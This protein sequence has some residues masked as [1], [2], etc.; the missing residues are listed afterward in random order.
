MRYQQSHVVHGA[1]V[2]V[3]ETITNVSKTNG[4]SFSFADMTISTQSPPYK[5]DGEDILPPL[6][7]IRLQVGEKIASFWKGKE[8]SL[9]T[10]TFD[11]KGKQW[12]DKIIHTFNAY[13]VESQES[14]TGAENI[15]TQHTQQDMV[16]ITLEQMKA[17]FAIRGMECI[18]SAIDKFPNKTQ[19]ANKDVR[20][21]I[22]NKIAEDKKA[23]EDG[24]PF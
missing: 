20:D 7:L 1:I 17:E 13:K 21:Y 12:N 2:S 19:W 23:Q 14:G 3:S 4:N 18:I 9:V 22:D 10:V 16:Y 6:N 15:H 24:M 8:G 5:R 11:I